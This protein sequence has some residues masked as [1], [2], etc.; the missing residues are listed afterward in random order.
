ME[1]RTCN[2][3]MCCKNHC[4]LPDGKN[5]PYLEAIAAYLANECDTPI[6][7]YLEFKT[8]T[9]IS[10]INF[11]VYETKRVLPTPCLKELLQ[12]ALFDY[13][14]TADKA[15][16]EVER[17]FAISRKKIDER[18][19]MH[20]FEGCRVRKNG[21]LINGFTKELLEQSRID[22]GEVEE[23]DAPEMK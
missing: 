6:E 16:N 20:M 21:N 5:M 10:E 1:Q 8:E 9:I 17:L 3:I 13:L 22:L 19:I 7:T 12:E 4:C 11:E 14:N 23:N 15:G 18:S 2:I